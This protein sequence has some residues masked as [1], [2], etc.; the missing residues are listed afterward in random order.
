MPKNNFLKKHNSGMTLVEMMVVLS[1]FGILS[2]MIMFDYGKFNSS[3]SMQNL[4]DDIA[5]NV[6]EAQ[7]YAIGARSLPGLGL[8]FFNGYGIHFTT[9]SPNLTNTVNGSNKSF[10][11]FT[12]II[13]PN[14][15]N[16]KYD[17]QTGISCGA[18]SLSNECYKIVN[19]TSAD[20]ISGI[21]LNEST[22]PIASSAS[23]D[24]V[25]TRPYPEASFC[26]RTSPSSACDST[27]YSSVT[28]RVANARTTAVKNIKISNTGQI[29]VN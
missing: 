20:Y 28:I 26:Y 12:D 14:I 18:P 25:F 16:K 24:I 10:I 9:A 6:R 7:S 8:G 17:F 29:S 21:Y 23:V 11:F 2:A 1:I 13:D 22:D 15:G 19:I 3:L 5:L 4:A 27:S